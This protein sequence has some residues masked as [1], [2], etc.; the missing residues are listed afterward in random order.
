MGG[1]QG[2]GFC[3]DPSGG[4]SG[5]GPPVETTATLNGPRASSP[6]LLLPAPPEVDAPLSPFGDK[7]TG[8]QEVTDEPTSQ[9]R[10]TAGELQARGL[11]VTAVVQG[12]GAGLG[13]QSC[14]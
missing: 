6:R 9:G 11:A 5:E 10:S 3:R 1:G 13:G 4:S 8:T 7:E 12:A 14:C 2:C